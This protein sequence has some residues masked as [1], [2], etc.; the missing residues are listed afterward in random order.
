V[1]AGVRFGLAQV[2]VTA[3]VAAVAGITVAIS[4]QL[5]AHGGPPAVAL[6]LAAVVVTLALPRV[7]RA[8]DRF[9]NGVVFGERADTYELVS[10]FVRSAASTL[11]IE[12]VLP[13]LAET[14]ARSVRSPRGEVRVWLA[15][16]DQWREAWPVT[17]AAGVPAVNVDVHH[18]GR[19]VGELEVSLMDE[20]A[21]AAATRRR[22]G[23]LAGPAGV[24][25]S[26]VRMTVDLRHRLDDLARTEVELRA[27]QRRL[28]E[29]RLEERQ[30]FVR[31]IDRFVS[32]HLEAA[33]KALG[34][35]S[36]SHADDIETELTTAAS[37]GELALERLRSL[38]HGVFPVVLLQAGLGE[39][40]SV[41]AEELELPFTVAPSGYP[42]LARRAP[43]AAAALYF[44]CV[45]ALERLDPPPTAAR[46]ELSEEA[47]SATLALEWATDGRSQL[48]PPTAL[49]L[50]D[51]AEAAGGRLMLS[52]DGLRVTVPTGVTG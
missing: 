51:R 45:E 24:A 7:R 47:G 50:R 32:P 42:E 31:T 10:D 5:G 36:C 38:A 35:A 6:L 30:R 17:P 1:R 52:S 26:T 44:C 27:S 22:L 33:T 9:A 4:L 21:D 20:E 48:D 19:P 34:A 23:T 3:F 43:T 12:E 37:Q 28:I 16:G 49:R 2:L 8:A 15:D 18:G 11:P 29:A 39:A 14:A 13:R 40:L 41:W 46:V 25:L